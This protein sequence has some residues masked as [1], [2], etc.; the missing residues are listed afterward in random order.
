MD[1]RTS[2][3]TILN[4]LGEAIAN[5]AQVIPE[6]LI[7]KVIKCATAKFVDGFTTNK[8]FKK[9]L[10]EKTISAD[11]VR[12][13]ESIKQGYIFSQFP[14][15]KDDLCPTWDANHFP[16]THFEAAAGP[17]Y[18]S[19]IATFLLSSPSNIIALGSCLKGPHCYSN[20][21]DFFGY[22]VPGFEDV[23][24]KTREDA[25]EKKIVNVKVLHTEGVMHKSLSN[26]I[27]PKGI[28]C[29]QL[30]IRSYAIDD[31]KK[32][33]PEIHHKNVTVFQ[34][35][36][37]TAI[38]L[39]PKVNSSENEKPYLQ[40]ALAR[41]QTLW[42]LFTRA[43]T[44]NTRIHCASGIGRTGH[45]ILTFELLKNYN[46]IFINQEPE[47]IAANVLSLLDRL[48]KNRPALVATGVQLQAAIYNADMLYRFALE[49]KYIEEGKPVH[50]A[51]LANAKAKLIPSNTNAVII[52][53][54]KL[55]GFKFN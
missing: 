11:L 18:E 9:Q 53:E 32:E 39:H 19:D 4:N 23:D 54:A 25:T 16:G 6:T 12:D 7:D 44:E 45:L 46:D 55:P 42:D 24:F 2:T 40:T 41:K 37:N 34:I 36:D 17:Q 22:M 1:T 31:I 33:H 3:T 52:E 28:V 26:Q 47:K 35:E 50:E 27:S 48:R 13:S 38:N 21:Y 14:Q 10:F 5:T 8:A 29:S 30:E 15:Y 20:H 49:K 51:A 43:L